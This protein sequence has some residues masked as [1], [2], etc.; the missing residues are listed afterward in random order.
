MR[1]ETPVFQTSIPFVGR[2]RFVTRYDDVITVAKDDR[3]SRDILPL[4]RWLPE[5]VR[6]PLTRQMLSQDPPEHTRLRKLVSQA[7]TPRRIEQLRGRI[8]TGC[9]ELLDAAPHIRS[10]D[11][12]RDYASHIPLNVIA[13]LLGIPKR[14]RQRFHHLTQRALPL[15]VASGALDM[16]VALPYLWLMMREFRSVG[17]QGFSRRFR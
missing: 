12:V 9:D 6:V 15:S 3:F 4:V 13:E 10:F 16:T 5:F 14:D 2:G 1:A 11:L 8:P 17:S 7:F